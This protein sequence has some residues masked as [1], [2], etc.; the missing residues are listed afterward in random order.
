MKKLITLVNREFWEQR[1]VFFT[2]PVVLGGLVI[3]A[4]FFTLILSLSNLTFN[5]IPI[6][7]TVD[8]FSKILPAI[9]FGIGT[10]FSIVLWLTVFYY[11]SGTLYDDRRD[12]SIL[13]WQSLPISQ[14]STLLSKLIAGLILAPFCAWV[15]MMAT[16]IIIFVLGS[17]FFMAH[18]IIP[19]ASLWH[20]LVMIHTWV[21]IF[22]VM[23]LQG[24]WLLPLLTWFMLCSAFAKRAPALI[25]TVSILI[26]LLFESFFLS[27]HYFAEFIFS[28]FSYAT[29]TWHSL[30]DQLSL[31]YTGSHSSFFSISYQSNPILISSTTANMLIGLG[32]SIIFIVLAGLLRSR[33]YGFEK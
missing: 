19:W 11:F 32:V 5:G 20:P 21:Q 15:S 22:L 33:C 10:P 13:F 28:R 8:E 14:T 29:Q 30:L 31:N 23:L 24:L 25:A 17:L 9:L 12:R 4:A 16:E 18:P 2:L 27:N 7:D 6:Q 26:V 1:N 3:L